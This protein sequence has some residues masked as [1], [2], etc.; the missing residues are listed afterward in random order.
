MVRKGHIKRPFSL[1]KIGHMT[2]V[3]PPLLIHCP[4]IPSR[5]VGG[6][7]REGVYDKN[8]FPD[9]GTL[10]CVIICYKSTQT[11]SST[12]LWSVS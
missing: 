11:C 9:G 8:E 10:L 12:N 5:E 7:N 2:A 1:A 6:L 3:Q 4:D